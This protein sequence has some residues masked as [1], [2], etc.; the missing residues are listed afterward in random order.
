MFNMYTKLT[1]A[2]GAFA[3][4]ISGG[5]WGQCADGEIAIDYAI[6]NGSYP[7]EISW[8]LNDASGENIF[9]GGAGEAGTWCLAPGDY[10]FIGIDSFGDG[11][12]GASAEFYNS[13]A[14]IGELAVEGGQGSVVLTVSADV[15]GC[16]DPAAGNYNPAATVDDGSCCLGNVLTFN[17][18]DAFGDGWSFGSGGAWGGIILNGTDSV[19]FASGSALSFDVCAEEGCYTAQISMG[20]WGQE[21]SWEV[22]QNGVVL[23]SGSGAGGSGTTFDADFFYYAGSGD[24]VVYGCAVE[25]ACNYNPGA[26]LDDGS[27]EFVSCAGCADE[28]ACNYEGA[29]LDDGSCDYSCIG[30]LDDTATN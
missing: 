1:T 4:L 21:A 16:T 15:P 29:T 30:C 5:A 17:L 26:N 19:E 28:G 9:T 6:S 8:Q 23:N 18:S 7:S 22:V 11:W 25:V 27:C 3:L 24:C 10:T 2:L 20:A 14:L 13:G 12:N